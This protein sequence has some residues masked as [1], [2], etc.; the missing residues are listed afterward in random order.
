MDAAAAGRPD[1]GNM[2][3]FSEEE[4]KIWLG[5]LSS[6]LMILRQMTG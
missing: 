6:R 3:S 1:A 2:G 4:D 5:Y